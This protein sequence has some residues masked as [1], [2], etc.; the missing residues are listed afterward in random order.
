LNDRRSTI[1]LNWRP[2][3]TPAR[4]RDDFAEVAFVAPAPAPQPPAVDRSAI[5]ERLLN[6]GRWAKS[7]DGPFAAACMTGAICDTMRKAAGLVEY[8][9]NN[10]SQAI[11]TNDAALVGRAMVRIDFDQR[12][13]LGLLYVEQERKGLI[14]AMLRIPPLEFDR[15]LVEAQ[16]A[17]D[18]ALLL[19]INANSK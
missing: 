7:A 15:H 9:L 18:A 10:S 13:L 4:R 11:D 16:D 1:T 3:G 14:A 17:I 19:C 2:M 5:E 12:R 6:W 8:S